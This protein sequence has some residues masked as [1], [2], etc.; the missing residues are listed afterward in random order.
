MA[1]EGM[2]VGNGWPVNLLIDL[3]GIAWEAT[4]QADT[5]CWGL[6]PDRIQVMHVELPAGEHRV[7]LYPAG[8][9]GERSPMRRPSRLK[10]AATPTCS[11]PSP[12]AE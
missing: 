6:L 1:K 9:Y 8:G 4:E 10:T 2:H 5:R 12:T 7:A 11:P 3:G